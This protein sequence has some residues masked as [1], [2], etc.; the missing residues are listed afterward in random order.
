MKVGIGTG[1]WHPGRFE[2]SLHLP[3]V[4]EMGFEAIELNLYKGRKHFDETNKSSIE[5]L[6]RVSDGLGLEVWSIHSPDVGSLGGEDRDGQRRQIESLRNC[7][8][9]A[10][11]LGASVVVSHGLLIAPFDEDL[12]GSETRLAESLEQLLMIAESVDAKIAFEN[13][14]IS[15]PGHRAID[16]LRRGN[17][18]SPSAFGFVL[19]TGHSN[20][21]GDLHEVC[22]N[23]GDRLISLHLNDNDGE[24][25]IHLPPGEGTVEWSAV[26]DVIDQ[27]HYG[28]CIMYEIEDIGGSRKPDEV[29]AS[30][31]EG[32]RRLIEPVLK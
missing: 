2:P 11:H 8:E 5:E 12:E 27:T 15:R 4:C 23:V 17:Q 16:V 32:H 24:R 9:L 25:D 29:L 26:A 7:L 3:I 6:L 14:T 1:L 19:D 31:M 18:T 28:R 30:T 21:A 20:I 10:E 13:G 22:G